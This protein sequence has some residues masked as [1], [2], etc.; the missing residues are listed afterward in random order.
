VIPTD[1]QHR[2]RALGLLGQLSSQIHP[3][4][5]RLPGLQFGGIVGAF[6]G[7]FNYAKD[8]LGGLAGSVLRKA[9]E[10]GFAPFNK[11]AE[12][13]LNALPNPLGLRNIAQK[14]RESVWEW[15]KGADSALPTT[16][17]GGGRAR[18]GGLFGLHE[19]V[20]TMAKKLLERAGGAAWIISGW[21]SRAQQEALYARYLAGGNLAARP[22]TSK[23]EKG[24]AVDWGGNQGIYQSIWRSLGGH[25]PV[26]GEPWHGEAIGYRNGTDFVPRDGLAYLHRGERVTPAGR[27]NGGGTVINIDL[28]GSV[29]VDDEKLARLVVQGIKTAGDKGIPITVRGRRL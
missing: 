13:G 11:A 28:R 6:K 18:G 3:L 12:V 15:V 25:F 1:P 10:V 21:R 27:R 5:A 2:G 20:A 26:R 22:G 8:R 14:A 29:G 4:S 9:L 23:H 16:P 19:P 17:P 24:L 7:G